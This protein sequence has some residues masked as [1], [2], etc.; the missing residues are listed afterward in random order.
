[1]PN[2]SAPAHRIRRSLRLITGTMVLFGLPTL[3][4]PIIF[5][6]SMTDAAT[7]ITELFSSCGSLRVL[8]APYWPS[9]VR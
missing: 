1:M 6:C 8:R 2:S 3:S 5:P 9:S 4:T 7:Y